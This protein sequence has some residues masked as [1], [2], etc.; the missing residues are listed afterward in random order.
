MRF[1]EAA[2]FRVRRPAPP[3]KPAKPVK[4]EL[5]R[6]RTL[7]SAETST[8][9]LPE[10]RRCH[11][12]STKPHPFEC[13]DRQRAGQAVPVNGMLQRS[14]TLSSAETGCLALD[15]A[16]GNASTKPHPFE[17][18][19]TEQ[20]D[21]AQLAMEQLQRSRTLSSAETTHNF[22][23]LLWLPSAS[24]KPHPFECGDLP[25]APHWWAL[26]AGF[27][28]AAPFRVR[29]LEDHPLTP[30]TAPSFN[31]AAPFRVRRHAAALGEKEITSRASTKPH[32]FECGDQRRID[33]C[34]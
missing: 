15:L 7:S 29:R 31:E 5:Q 19:D 33:F 16:H 32:P 14:R 22:P 24:T 17:C 25:P 13:G 20:V 28:E 18:G 2:P 21:N 9:T 8:S 3:A 12:A 11:N 23:S 30:H 6:S 27:N 1:N 34:P 26:G 10:L 4:V